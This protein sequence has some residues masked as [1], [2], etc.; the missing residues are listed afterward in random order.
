MKLHWWYLTLKADGKAFMEWYKGRWDEFYHGMNQCIKKLIPIAATRLRNYI[1]DQVG[2]L[3]IKTQWNVYQ[4]TSWHDRLYNQHCGYI[5]RE[6]KLVWAI[7]S[8]HWTLLVGFCWG[9]SSYWIQKDINQRHQEMRLVRTNSIL[10][11]LIPLCDVMII[12][13]TECRVIG[14]EF[15]ALR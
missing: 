5:D 6:R 12:L 9:K 3:R 10:K 1:I 14:S 7:F 8:G 2:T 13:S 15:T 11:K 4:S